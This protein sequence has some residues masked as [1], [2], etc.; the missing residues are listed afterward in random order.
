MKN[1]KKDED[2]YS[3]NAWQNLDHEANAKDVKFNDNEDHG[4]S[5]NK[6]LEDD[7][8][9]SN[10]QS[11][12]VG[13]KKLLKEGGVNSRGLE[14]AQATHSTITKTPQPKN[15]FVKPGPAQMED[16]QKKRTK[17]RTITEI[18]EKV[19]TWRKLYNGV[20][21]PNKETKEV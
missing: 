7:S 21:I 8:D 2:P 3:K 15:N 13:S 1:I 16:G 18:I 17:E 9:D 10:H 12:K 5:D 14:K 20:M 11:R 4:S 19:S 6:N